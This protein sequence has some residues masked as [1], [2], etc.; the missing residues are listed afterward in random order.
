MGKILVLAEKPS[1]G[2][3]LAR[4]LGCKRKGAGCLIGDKYIVTWALGHLV[5]LA[6]PEAY[7]DKYKTWSFD[8]LPMLPDKMKLT[9]IPQTSKQYNNVKKLMRSSEVDSL[10]IATDA[11]REGELVA[12]W[13]IAKA[14]FKKPIKRLWISSQTDKAIRQGFAALKDG[15][16]YYNLYMS[17]QARAEADWLVGLN[18]TRALTCKFNAQ[19]SAGRVQTPTLAL[20]IERENSIKNFRPKEYYTI[21]ADLGKLFAMWRDK[22]KNSATFDRAKA[23]QIAETVRGG[24][25]KVT[26]IRNTEKQTP[27]PAL[28]DLTELQRDA[29]KLYGYSPKQTLGIMQ[30]LYEHH[31]AL[32]YPRT[33]SRYLTDDIVPTLGERVRAV[34]TGDNREA[35]NEILRNKYKI[36]KGCVNNSKV[37]DHHAIIPT[38]EKVSP[39]TLS[40]EEK[41]IYDLVVK[42]F[43]ACFYPS[44]KYKQIKAEFECSGETFFAS[45]REEIDPGWKKIYSNRMFDTDDENEN[46]LENINPEQNMPALGYSDKFICKNTIVKSGRTKPPARYTEASLLSAM[47]NPAA[48][49]SDKKMREYLG[50]GLGTPATRADIIDKLYSAFYVEKQGNSMVPTSKGAQLIN[51]VPQDLKEPVMTAKWEMELEKIS[52]GKADKEKFISEIRRYAADL[53]KTVKNSQAEYRHD[54]MTHKVCPECGKF[55]LEVNGKRGKMLV[56]QDRECGYRQNISLKTNVR[57]P[58]CHKTMEL[59]GEGEKRTYYCKCG[60][61][62]RYDAYKKRMKAIHGGASKNEVRNYLKNQQKHEEIN[63]AFAAAFAKLEKNGDK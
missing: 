52:K 53:V 61:R 29:N 60:Y 6:D 24:A 20:L 15:K 26:S 5:T 14:G 38:E 19:L 28:Y 17:A 50:G 54:N 9:V 44:Y 59:F 21:K 31:K 3:E 62:E 1:V 35:A 57:C 63:D 33:D 11:G 51:L 22:N 55:L 58:E 27:P 43:L 23:E 47:E 32:T 42:R 48:F 12:R 46:E 13:I 40:S 34:M 39:M 2:R 45:G 56:C 36:A 30:R 49:V 4:V 7:D 18:V 16:D 25:F 37:S 41:R 8:T 10:I